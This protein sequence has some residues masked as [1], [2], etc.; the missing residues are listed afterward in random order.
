MGL[1]V[2]VMYVSR[3]HEKRNVTEW[4]RDGQRTSIV[5]ATR[6]SITNEN[7][8]DGR[9]IYSIQLS[10]SGTDKF[11]ERRCGRVGRTKQYSSPQREILQVEVV[12][13]WPI[14]LEIV[15]WFRRIATVYRQA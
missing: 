6:F 2:A 10:R 12:S 14:D 3:G 8:T 4:V 13:S 9:A 1:H 7:E 15:G 5:A 11:I